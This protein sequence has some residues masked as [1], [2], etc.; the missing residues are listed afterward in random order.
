M[1]NFKLW[2]FTTSF[3]SM[4]LV[5][6]SFAF[7]VKVDTTDNTEIVDLRIFTSGITVVKKHLHI[8]NGYNIVDDFALPIGTVFKSIVIDGIDV[9]YIKNN[10]GKYI[11]LILEG[12]IISVLT[13]NGVSYQG[14]ILNPEGWNFGQG[15]LIMMLDPSL[16]PDHI[17]KLIFI[18]DNE[19]S[20]MQILQFANNEQINSRL[21]NENLMQIE[22][23][24]TVKDKEQSINYIMRNVLQWEP[25]YTLDLLTGKI[26]AYAFLESYIDFSNANITFVMGS[27]LIAGKV[28][29]YSTNQKMLVPVEEAIDSA[30]FGLNQVGEMWEYKYN[31]KLGL[32]KNESVKLPLFSGKLKLSNIYTWNGAKVLLKH[33]FTNELNTPLPPGIIDNY[34]DKVWVGQSELKWV[35]K[36]EKSEI[37]SQYAKDI[38]IEEIITEQT[39]EMNKRIISKKIVINNHKEKK[40]R[41]EIIRNLPYRSN[42]IKTSPNNKQDGSKLTWDIFVDDNQSKSINYTYETLLSK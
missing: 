8:E 21:I 20:S 6:T 36:G 39:E 23:S 30:G 29:P 26:S 10:T 40:I 24:G 12:D 5:F 33:K 11:N 16:S 1:G 27:P 13:K 38:E 9:E 34:E 18:S 17:E 32:Y 14:E 3:I 19:I 4:L 2:T 7:A 31:E 28:S 25:I 42:L 35:A 15:S 22:I 37:L 41:I